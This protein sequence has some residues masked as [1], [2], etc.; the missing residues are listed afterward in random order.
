VSKKEIE[1]RFGRWSVVEYDGKHYYSSCVDEDGGLKCYSHSGD[2]IVEEEDLDKVIIIQ[3]GHLWT[4]IGE[5]EYFR[6]RY[7]CEASRYPD[8]EY[9]VRP[10]LD[11]A[12]LKGKDGNKISKSEK[13]DNLLTF[14]AAIFE[15]LPDDKQEIIMEEIGPMWKKI[16]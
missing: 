1:N 10:M 5:N 8:E 2:I 12:L 14:V 13:I 3:K 4:L 6:Q 15:A 7:P 16:T 11:K 9:G